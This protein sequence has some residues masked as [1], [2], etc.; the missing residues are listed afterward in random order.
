M[1]PSERIEELSRELNALEK[2][3]LRRSH[4]G[5]ALHQQKPNPRAIPA[6]LDEQH[7]KLSELRKSTKEAIADA[8][9]GIHV[10][11]V[12]EGWLFQLDEFLGAEPEVSAKQGVIEPSKP[13]N[14]DEA[15]QLLVNTAKDIGDGTARLSESNDVLHEGGFVEKGRAESRVVAEGPGF[16][17]DI[18]VREH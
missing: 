7:T 16:T 9:S 15:F 4:P 18:R 3:A 12:L 11:L 13:R 14:A 5:L 8:R 1:K 10:M 2:E 17:V 6:Y